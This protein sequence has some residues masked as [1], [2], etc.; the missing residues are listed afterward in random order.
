MSLDAVAEVLKGS[1]AVGSQRLLL[2]AL[3]FHKNRKSGRCDPSMKTLAAECNV[4]VRS[5]ERHLKRLAALGEI[6][7]RSGFSCGR[8]NSYTLRFAS[9]QAHD[10]P[11]G[12]PDTRVVSTPTPVSRLPD[13]YVHR[14][15]RTKETNPS[16]S[17]FLKVPPRL[18]L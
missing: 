1:K 4:S 2:V 13:N 8:R 17:G 6:E 3:A 5:I 14:T 10:L 15:V 11:I 7:I 12:H 18:Q 9:Q 16:H